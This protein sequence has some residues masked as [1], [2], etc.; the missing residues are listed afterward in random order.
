M[1]AAITWE[2]LAR[3]SR[4]SFTSKAGNSCRART[5]SPTRLCKPGRQ[6]GELL[7]RTR[8]RPVEMDELVAGGGK[9]QRHLLLGVEDD[10]RGRRPE[11][12][13]CIEHP[14]CPQPVHPGAARD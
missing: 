2:W 7:D 5:V 14:G 6:R 4:A 1:A 13:P 8:Q 11:L 12:V 3:S 9:P 10:V